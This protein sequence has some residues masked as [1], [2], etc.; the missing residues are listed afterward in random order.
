MQMENIEWHKSYETGNPNIDAEHM[1]FFNLVKKL[2][3]ALKNKKDSHYLS[4]IIL[5]IQKYAEF[6]FV[7]EENF[8][9]EIDYPEFE[10]HQLKHLKLLEKFNVTLNFVELGKETYEDFA[11]FL[12]DWFK[13]HTVNEDMEIA[14]FIENKKQ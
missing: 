1:I 3:F 8:M 5:E 2:V 13:F 7:S 12:I 11:N 14:T 9:I 4:R 10:S 6:H